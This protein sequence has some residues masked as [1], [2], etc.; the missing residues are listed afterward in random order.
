M[1]PCVYLS[2]YMSLFLSISLSDH[3]SIYPPLLC[4]FFSS[5]FFLFHI[6]PPFPSFVPSLP[7]MPSFV[8]VSQSLL[9]LVNTWSG[10]AS[11]PRHPPSSCDTSALSSAP[12]TFNLT[13]ALPESPH[14][15]A[16]HRPLG[17]KQNKW[18]KKRKSQKVK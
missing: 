2:I 12:E 17:R 13:F 4:T 1:F 5:L 16:P 14:T 7:P 11:V 6:S 3:L 9:P 8:H 18:R 10:S 15:R